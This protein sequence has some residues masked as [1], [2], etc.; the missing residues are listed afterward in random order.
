MN[1]EKCAQD[2]HSI[3]IEIKKLM[4]NILASEDAKYDILRVLDIDKLIENNAKEEELLLRFDALEKKRLDSVENFALLNGCGSELSLTELTKFMSEDSKNL[5]VKVAED[6][7]V[8]TEQ[9]STAAERNRHILANNTEIIGNILKIM[10]GAIS[11]K[12]DN[13]GSECDDKHN[14][15]L[16]DHTV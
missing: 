4:E 14:L 16:L 3:L 12:Y 9:L 11:Q 5:C 13:S 7:R 1:P 2:L 6:I 8:L 15:H 10:D